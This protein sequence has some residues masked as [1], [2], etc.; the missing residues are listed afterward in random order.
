[1]QSTT[2]PDYL[3]I[4]SGSIPSFHKRVGD[5]IDHGNMRA[6]SG[7]FPVPGEQNP[8]STSVMAQDYFVSEATWTNI[9]AYGKFDYIVIGSGFTALAFI[10]ET[11]KH[12]VNKRIL[13]I[14]RGDFWLPSHFQNLPLPFKMVLG[15]PSETFPWTLSRKTF[16][17]KELGFCHGSCPFFGGRS[18]FWSAWSPK[19][20]KSLMRDFPEELIKTTEEKDFWYSAK[21]LL[22]VTP[23]TK[24]DDRVF[25]GLQEAIDK[26]LQKELSKIPTADSVES[27]PLAVGPR[28]RTSLMRFNKFSVPG[29]LL[30]QYENQRVLAEKEKG[31]PLELMINCTATGLKKDD[32]GVVRAIE[33]SR[34]VLSWTD[35]DTKVVLC[36]GAIPNATLLLNSFYSCHQTVGKRLTGHFQ[37][38][39]TARCLADNVDWKSN[40]FL[41]IAATYLAGM[42]PKT[43]RQY[44]VQITAIH[45]PRP[46]D[47]ADDAAR[48]CP[49]YAAAATYEQLKDSENYVVFVCASLGELD[50]S[51][52]E[53][54]VRLND[55]KD[56]SSNVTLQLTLTDDDKKLWDTMDKATFETIEAMSGDS[57]IVEYWDTHNGKWSTNKP[58]TEDIRIPGVVHEAST[59]F[60]GPESKGG[61]LD[62]FYRPHEVA[63]VFVTGAALFPTAGSW[64]P[65][66]TMCGFA[67]DLARKLGENPGLIPP[68]KKE[69]VMPLGSKSGP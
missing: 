17:T 1:M 26:I 33:T 21:K 43:H 36:A 8:T 64:N 5:P 3:K 63:N 52:K 32:D 61:S 46:Q 39:I 69:E 12:D 2:L 58:P 13:C 53:N 48:E 29:P 44:H 11:L 16:K 22:N 47:D 38:H 18:T 20:D 19:P 68:S 37:S 50:E 49:D 6:S 15:G 30:A 27:A 62:S 7:G 56:P 41:E 42:D 34:G 4:P 60:V 23:A 65:T 55:S 54:F 24:I 9:L 66:L 59:A 10:T 25:S 45:S 35:D 51:N 57:G 67:Q 31:M 28:A 40:G 14:E